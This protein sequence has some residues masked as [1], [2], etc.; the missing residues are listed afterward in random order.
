MSWPGLLLL[1]ALCTACASWQIRADAA[2]TGYGFMPGTVDYASCM[3]RAATAEQQFWQGLVFT[4][5]EAQQAQQPVTCTTR[6]GLLT[7]RTT[8]R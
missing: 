6:Q 3:E 7:Q 5:L 2:C 1:L 8:C 4:I